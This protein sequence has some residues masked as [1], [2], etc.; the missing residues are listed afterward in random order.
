MEDPSAHAI[1]IYKLKLEDASYRYAGR[2][3]PQA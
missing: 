1:V 3:T 2:N